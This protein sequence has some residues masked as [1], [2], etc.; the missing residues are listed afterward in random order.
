MTFLGVKISNFAEKI[1]DDFFLVIDHIFKIFPCFSQIF[2]IFAIDVL[3]VIFDPF[4]T[5]K[6]PFFTLLILSSA[7]DNTTS[8]NIG[9]DQCMGYP[10]TS[11]FG[12]TVPPRPPP[13]LP[14]KLCTRV[15]KDLAT[16]LDQGHCYFSVYLSSA[17]MD[18]IYFVGYSTYCILF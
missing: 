7:S 8:L 3:N 4:L 2:P 18:Y 13:L 11:N 16:P 9:G 1:S 12:G 17:V 14:P 6:T 10:P 15:P 5:R